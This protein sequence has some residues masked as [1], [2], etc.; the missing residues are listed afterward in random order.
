MA[1]SRRYFPNNHESS[2]SSSNTTPSSIP[3][4]RHQNSVE[5]RTTQSL[6]LEASGCSSK[7]RKR[8]KQISATSPSTQPTRRTGTRLR[9]RVPVLYDTNYHPMDEVLRPNAHAT[10]KARSHRLVSSSCKRGRRG[11]DNSRERETDPISNTGMKRNKVQASNKN[12]VRKS[13]RFNSSDTRSGKRANYN[14]RYHP[15]DDVRTPKRRKRRPALLKQVSMPATVSTS[16]NL[17]PIDFDNPFTKSI[18]SDWRDVGVFDRRVYILQKGAPLRG[19]TLPLEW[20]QVIDTL[21]M[22]GFFSKLEFETAGGLSALVSRYEDLRLKLEKFFQSAPEPVDKR[23][24]PIRYVE[25]LKVYKFGSG[26]KYLGHRRQSVVCPRSSKRANLE[27]VVTSNGEDLED[28]RAADLAND[29]QLT[30]P[31]PAISYTTEQSSFESAPD[32]QVSDYDGIIDRLH[33]DQDRSF[34]EAFNLSQPSIP[35]DSTVNTIPGNPSVPSNA[36]EII[37]KQPEHSTAESILNKSGDRSIHP[38][39]LASDSKNLVKKGSRDSKAKAAALSFKIHEDEP[40]V[41]PLTRKYTSMNPPSPGTD[42]Q[43]ENFPDRRSPGEDD[44]SDNY[45]VRRSRSGQYLVAVPPSSQSNRFRAVHAV[46]PREPIFESPPNPEAMTTESTGDLVSQPSI[47]APT[48]TPFIST[49]IN[50]PFTPVDHEE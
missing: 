45:I 38:A 23:D 7:E 29:G 10:L 26:T 24:W 28:R 37:P 20:T 35:A 46:Q 2:S 17:P 36:A 33:D 18:P 6:N 27:Q 16:T 22:E 12:A 47:Q 1:R 8:P 4:G 39:P 41:T 42:I 31:I 34:E 43:K 9:G 3:A 49:R 50:L 40:G 15:V 11:S 44:L 30:L 48:S 19:T 5:P 13:P 32:G 21:V 25:D 14:M